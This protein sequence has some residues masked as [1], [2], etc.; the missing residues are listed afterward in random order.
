MRTVFR[1]QIAD[2]NEVD[3]RRVTV[4]VSGINPACRMNSLGREVLQCCVHLICQW[5]NQLCTKL[6]YSNYFTVSRFQ[7]DIWSIQTSLYADILPLHQTR[8]CRCHN[9]KYPYLYKPMKQHLSRSWSPTLSKISSIYSLLPNDPIV[10]HFL[11]PASALPSIHL[12]LA[13]FHVLS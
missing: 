1:H 11:S 2:R 12:L 9:E 8:R 5:A 3:I 4:G 13:R 7:P 10:S 6:W